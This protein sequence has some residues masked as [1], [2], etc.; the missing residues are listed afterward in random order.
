MDSSV[1]PKD[2]IWFLRLCHHISNAVYS[3]GR[4]NVTCLHELVAWSIAQKRV[5]VWSATGRVE[6]V[7]RESEWLE[8]H[9]H[10]TV[11]S[12]FTVWKL[13]YNWNS[14]GDV[15]CWDLE[16]MD[17]H[18]PA[19]GCLQYMGY[20]FYFHLLAG[21][22]L[23]P[24]PWFECLLVILL[25]SASFFDVTKVEAC[26]VIA[27]PWISQVKSVYGF[28]SPPPFSILPRKFSN[29]PQYSEWAG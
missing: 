27:G 3:N 1:S 18:L 19:H 29:I 26:Y 4:E 14:E 20:I 21:F 28:I 9:P 17:P 10:F 13:F 11:H 24:E 22:L 23:L 7:T 12:T 5:A 25:T 2:E 8:V 15:R 6:V 16:W